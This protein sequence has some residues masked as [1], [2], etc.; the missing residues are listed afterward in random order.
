MEDISVMENTSE[1]KKRTKAALE[2]W[3]NKTSLRCGNKMVLGH[4]EIPEV[5]HQ[6]QRGLRS[7]QITM[8]TSVRTS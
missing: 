7:H 4:T 5:I 2:L 6:H 1:A 8:E 3:N